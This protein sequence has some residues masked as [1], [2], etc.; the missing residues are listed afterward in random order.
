MNCIQR[1]TPVHARFFATLVALGGLGA[2]SACTG[3]VETTGAA[4]PNTTNTPGDGTS[5]NGPTTSGNASSSGSVVPTAYDGQGFVVHEWGTNTVV[6]GSD[7]S[8]QVGM[9]HEEEGLPSFVYDR[10]K[11]NKQDGVPATDKLETPV[12]YFYSDKPRKVT[13][14]VNF[15]KGVLTQWYPQVVQTLPVVGWPMQGTAVADP[16]LDRTFA[17]GSEACR[18]KFGTPANGLLDW[19]TIEILGPGEAAS[20]PAAPLDQ[21]TWSYARDVKANV[22]RNARGQHENYLFYRGLGNFEQPALVTTK[23]LGKLTLTNKFTASVSSVFVIHVESRGGSFNEYQGE[24]A[25][26]RSLEREVPTIGKEDLDSYAESL[27]QAVT[28]A[29][30]R[31]GLYHDEAVGMVNTWKRQ[32][33]RTPGTRV[34]YIAPQSWTDAVLPLTITPKPDKTTRVLLLR[35]EVISPEV[36]AKDLEGLQRFAGATSTSDGETYFRAL[37]RFAEPRLRRALSLASL[38]SKFADAQRGA[39]SFLETIATKETSSAH[40]E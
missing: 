14:K 10:I 1:H 12:T 39:V 27:G 21:Y 11:S 17:F 13:A 30:D 31:S 28:N 29:L 22:I 9:H 18:S 24:V 25:S 32:W 36:E 5:A 40:G 4:A 34:L 8:L 23:A 15:P 6:V 19:G 20:V 3:R 16:A 37:G 7:G 33:F 35:I 2:I 38:D 26:G